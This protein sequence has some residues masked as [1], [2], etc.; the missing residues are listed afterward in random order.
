MTDIASPQPRLSSNPWSLYQAEHL[1]GLASRGTSEGFYDRM[2]RDD[3]SNKRF[4]FEISFVP[5]RLEGARASELLFAL[6]NDFNRSGYDRD[7]ASIVCDLVVE[8]LEESSDGK[9]L[10]V[11][12]YSLPSE[13]NRVKRRAR[14]QETTDEGGESLPSLGLIPNWSAK[15]T[16]TGFI[17]VSPADEQQTI[18]IPKSR[19]HSLQLPR[20][21]RISWTRAVKGLQLVDT[22]KP[23]LSGVDRLSWDGFSFPDVVATQNLAVACSTAEIGWDGRGTFAESVTS[24]YMTFRRLRFTKFWIEALQEAVAFLNEFTTSE[25]LYGENAFFFSLTGLPTAAD[26][27]LAM[28]N[29]RS[30]KLTIDEAHNSYLYPKLST[31]KSP[32]PQQD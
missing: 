10:L 23:L 2:L 14:R 17:Q 27:N 11:E 6:L 18:T 1:V 22:A 15:K 32:S 31:R 19:V 7:P 9:A 29:I 5:D 26:L 20:Q 8:L 25:S 13:H 4:A 12:L 30:G 3:L 21:S 24:P 16:R 28:H